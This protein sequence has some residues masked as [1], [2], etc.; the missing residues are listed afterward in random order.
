MYV[1]YVI[2]VLQYQIAIVSTF[3]FCRDD[4]VLVLVLVLVPG[5]ERQNGTVSFSTLAL[6]RELVFLITVPGT[7]YYL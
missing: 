5:T 2:V 4:V 1:Y 6:L 3:G 7:R